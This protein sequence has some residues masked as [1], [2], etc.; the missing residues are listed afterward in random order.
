MFNEFIYE[1]QF[2]IDI[3]THIKFIEYNKKE[4]KLCEVAHIKNIIKK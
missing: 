3:D 2:V 4:T 1:N